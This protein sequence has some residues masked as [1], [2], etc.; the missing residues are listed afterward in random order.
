MVTKSAVEVRLTTALS[1]L[2]DNYKNMR[3]SMDSNASRPGSSLSGLGRRSL[4]ALGL[5]AAAGATIAPGAFAQGT[6]P[7]L[8]GKPVTLGA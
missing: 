6:A 4:M 8:S 3:M 2:S 7:A 5:G 1:Y